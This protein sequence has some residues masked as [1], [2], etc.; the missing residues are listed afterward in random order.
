M[1]HLPF[2]G[3]QQNWNHL[4]HLIDKNQLAGAQLF[5]GLNGIGKKIVAQTL[6]QYAFCEAKHQPQTENLFGEVSSVQIP[7]LTCEP[8]SKVIN[9]T[10]PDFFYIEPEGKFIKIDQIRKLQRQISRTPL[11][12]DEKFIIINDAQLLNQ[13]SSN[14]LLKTLE[15]PPSHTHFIL[16]STGVFHVLPTIRS[17]CQKVFFQSPDV[18][19]VLSMIK[20]QY[21]NIDEKDM[22]SGL[23]LVDHSPGLFSLLIQEEFQKAESIVD[24]IMQ[25]SLDYGRVVN[26]VNNI[27]QIDIDLVFLL[28]VI[29][30]KIFLLFKD[31]EDDFHLGKIELLNS[32]QKDIYSQVQKNLVLENLFLKIFPI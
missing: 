18:K 5:Y 4:I 6:V 22:A 30:K 10:H 14:S 1:E 20:K 24:E 3:H 21:P 31:K 29:K 9:Q 8:C 13:A 32:A 12:A 16:I 2:I 25:T 28:E 11:E 23:E 7:C 26:A 27:T 15:E 19:E 17:R